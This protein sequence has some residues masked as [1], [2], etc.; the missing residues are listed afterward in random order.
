MTTVPAQPTPHEDWPTGPPQDTAAE[1]AVLGSL[2]QSPDTVADVSEMLVAA[3][4]YKPAHE[5]IY[6]AVLQ[7]AAAGEPVDPITVSSKLDRSGDLAR[8]G[9]PGYVQGLVNAASVATS[10]AY[11]AEIIADKAS[12]RRLVTAGTRIAQLAQAGQGDV[13]EICDEA[14]REFH[15]AIRLAETSTEAVPLKHRAQA[16]VDSLDAEARG[17]TVPGIPTGVSDL[18]SLLGGG[19]KPGQMV[20]VAG[21]PAM[22]KSTL[23][24]DFARR[25]TI[26]RNHTAVIFSL[27]MGREQLE[28]R[29]TS[30][31]GRVPLH[32]LTQPS[33]LTEA[34][35]V[36]IA[37]ATDR[38]ADANLFIDDSSSLTVTQIRARARRIQQ[39]HGLDLI[40]IDYL[41][42]LQSGLG[43]VES[44]QVEVSLMSRSIKLLAKELGV[45][46]VVLC[47]LNRG[48]EQRT[49]KKPVLSDLRESGSLEQDAD[50]VILVHR[51]DAYDPE[52][53]RA[54]EA[55][56][57]VAKNR[58]GHTPIITV[59]FQGH[60]A[61]FT[62]MGGEQE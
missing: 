16:I 13:A 53:P 22:G 23:A 36:R 29:I 10:A 47:Q 6:R 60:Y 51:E 4:F 32:R 42:L 38:F 14:G 39:R 30:A 57:I 40:V 54:G 12:L 2:L 11:Y 62:D 43:R 28:R 9:G 31:T 5:T 26:K 18:D 48:P 56:L 50:I 55:D 34:D 59:A 17:K 1:Q 46:V 35:W 52:S 45:P 44:R 24:V 61:R 37:T 33:R 19:L 20:I 27:E 8:V 25:A 7:L 21:R 49:D 3:D 15:E 58:D 41:Q